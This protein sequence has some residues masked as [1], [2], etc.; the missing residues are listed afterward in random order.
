MA[1]QSSP[2]DL[3]PQ[4]ERVAVA[5]GIAEMT[6]SRL[7]EVSPFIQSWP[8]VRLKKVT[9]PFSSVCSRASRFMNPTIRTSPPCQS[10][11]TAGSNPLIFSKSSSAPIYVF[12]RQNK[13][14]AERYASAGRT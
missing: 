10:C 11:T 2:F 4:Q 9:Y 14:P 7:P 13:K 3:D 6:L 12:L 5:I 8:R 1:D